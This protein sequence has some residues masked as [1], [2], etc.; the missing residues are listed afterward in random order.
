LRLDDEVLVTRCLEGDQPAFAFLVNKYKEVVH[1]YAYRKVADYQHAED[2]T[3]EVF[4]K[5]YRKLAQLKWPHRFQSWLYAITSNECKL[6][7]RRHS[8]EQEQE[9]SWEEVPAE[10]LDELAAR[11]HGDEEIKLTVKSA[12]E[13]LSD[14]NQLAVSLY[15]MSN[16]SVKEIAHFMGVSPNSV[17]IKLHRARKHL[18]ERL[19]KMIGKHLSKE[20]LKAGFVFKVVDAIRDMPIPSL[21]KPRPIRWAPSPIAIGIALL[22]G[23]I[24][25]GTSSV[26]DVSSD[27]SILEPAE[28][29]FGVSL[30]ADTN[31]Q[32]VL[33]TVSD[34]EV[35]NMGSEDIYQSDLASADAGTTTQTQPTAGAASSGVVVRRVWDRGVDDN[36]TVSPD[37]RYISY[38]NWANKGNVAIHDFET[39]ESRDVTDEDYQ[40]KDKQY[41]AGSVW[42]PDSK[43]LAYLWFRG[44][45]RDL[46]IVGINGSKPR[47]LYSNPPRTGMLSP[48]AWSQDGKH[49]LA[50]FH[51]KPNKP[52]EI[53]LVSV[54][55]GSIRVL[56][57]LDSECWQGMS[58]SPDGHYVVY[59]FH[60]PHPP[61]S[62]NSLNHDIGLVATDGSHEMTLVEHPADD[63]APFWTPDGNRIVFAS[64]RSGSMGIWVLD[65]ADG[66][67]K[68][69]PQLIKQN[70]NG[71]IPLGL[72]Q[73]GSYYYTL[74]IPNID[75]YLATLDP[76]TGEVVIPPAKAIQ[77]FEGRN[78]QPVFSPDGKYLAY[79]SQRPRAWDRGGFKVLVIRSLETSEER[80]LSPKHIALG[81]RPCWSPDG[82]SILTVVIGRT[83]GLDVYQIDTETGA[84]TP[85][86]RSDEQGNISAVPLALSPDG[87]KIFFMRERSGTRVI[88]IYDFETKREWEPDFQ[89][90]CGES[91][92]G[93]LALSPDGQ[94]LAFV[95][96]CDNEW[97]FQIAPSSGGDTREVLRLPREEGTAWGWGLTWTPDG[98][99]LLFPGELKDFATG[100]CEL[101][102]VPV[103]GGEPQNLGL[104][105]TYRQGNPSFHPDGRRIAFTGPGSGHSGVWA[106]ENFLPG[107][108]ADK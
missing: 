26:K 60:S 2:I 62:E 74:L 27:I 101:W 44:G 63:R 36:W 6:W 22:I 21:P 33:D 9:V 69:S 86:V 106:M 99:H 11:A 4:I 84:A 91:Y 39:G 88:R 80:V 85:V 53:V 52:S 29:T 108:T 12:M 38:P 89:L 16:L 95:V 41:A 58:L 73:D 70:L 104:T 72:T 55:D 46:R 87:S 79:I 10:N 50:L 105:T 65:V 32:T 30:L 34:M 43:H 103:E 18:G 102:R 13:T 96:S 7:L 45:Y 71:I 28:T 76:E 23:I 61:Q 54:A 75:V 47:V 59:D 20:K 3:Q 40:G 68:G 1:A 19:E 57:S 66:K 14:D 25:Y 17:R 51:F 49:I 97:S 8:R 35:L 90:T 83:G 48:R 107:F 92:S 78:S 64:D 81:H 94:Q 5:A 98:R 24:G 82:R 56:K 42:S 100:L 93:R 15:Y 67:P 37:G 77:S 31:G